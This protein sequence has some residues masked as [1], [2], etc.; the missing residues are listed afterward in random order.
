MNDPVKT[1]IEKLEKDTAFTVR[2]KAYIE[3]AIRMVDFFDDLHDM[4]LGL[5]KNTA[6]LKFNVQPYVE[7]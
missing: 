6:G 3:K 2:E 4:S 1:I 5:T 7:G